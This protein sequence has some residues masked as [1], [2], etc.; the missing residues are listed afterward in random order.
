MDAH[1]LVHMANR[2]GEFFEAMPDAAEASDGVALHIQK[3]WAPQMRR[4]LLAHM[5]AHLEGGPND[6]LMPLVRKSILAHR[7]LLQPQ[8]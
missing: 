7:Q 2:I 3:F 5:D 4:E 1:N 8:S 6:G